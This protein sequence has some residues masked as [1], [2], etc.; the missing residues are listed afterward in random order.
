MYIETVPNRNSPPA[1]LLRESYR[2]GKKVLK[3]T[4]AKL[5]DWPAQKIAAFRNML[6]DEPLQTPQ[7]LFVIERS[8]P[9]GHVQS[10]LGTLRKIGLETML[11]TKPS[12]QRDLV[13]AMIVERL[14]FPCS[15]LAATR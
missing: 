10:V 11:G 14:I 8:L 4:L 2:D 7:E 9:H 1:V 6:R 3:L 5:S 13:V 12:R 15:K